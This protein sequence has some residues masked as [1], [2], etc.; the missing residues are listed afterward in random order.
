M[1]YIYR[2]RRT[3]NERTAFT[4]FNQRPSQT[5]QPAPQVA[6]A[7]QPAQPDVAAGSA[8]DYSTWSYADLQAAAKAQGL[9]A[10][11]SRAELEARLAGGD[12]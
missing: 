2:V 4:R 6:P 8:T 5:H 11:G 12:Q 1:P 10:G 9:S 7:D 3:T